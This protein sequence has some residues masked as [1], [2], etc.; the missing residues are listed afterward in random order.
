MRRGIHGA[1]CIVIAMHSLKEV[2][3]TEQPG[4]MHFGLHV[5]N[6]PEE[7]R[8]AWQELLLALQ[9][10]AGRHDMAELAKALGDVHGLYMDLPEESRPHIARQVK[11][12]A[13]KGLDEY[14]GWMMG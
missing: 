3:L 8:E 14:L 2:F 11:A 7:A 9:S 10:A 4:E 12:L 13:Q 6:I 5:L 1:G